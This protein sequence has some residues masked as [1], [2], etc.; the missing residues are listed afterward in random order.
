MLKTIAGSK[1]PNVLRLENVSKKYGTRTVLDGV[2]LTIPA[3]EYVSLL[4][5][6][7]SGKTVLLRVIAGFE[8]PDGGRVFVD[9]IR[10]D[11][12]PAHRRGIG[13]VFQNF[14]LFPHLNVTDNIAYGLTYGTH[15][16]S[17]MQSSVRAMIALVGLEGL[18]DRGVHQIS[19]GQR[20]RVALARTLV[21]EPRLVLL[22]EPLGAL[23]AHLRARMQGE[24]RA[25][26]EQLGV[27][28]LHVTGNET[29]ALAMGDRTI[30][31][32]EGRV[33]QV[34]TP[35]RIYNAP[36]SPDVARF[37]NSYNL[38]EGTLSGTRFTA[39]CGT[40]DV[41]K[42]AA[43]WARPTYAIR[44][45]LVAIRP[46]A[47]APAA[48]EAGTVARFVADEYSGPTILYLFE[49]PD[50]NMVEV[51]DHLSHRAPRTLVPGEDYA[52]VWKSDDAV[53]FG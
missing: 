2:S 8:Q 49:L 40:F 18:E 43:P 25:I 28:F 16:G 36:A 17:A 1:R 46:A 37:L 21:T 14:A 23:D 50:R 4:G 11:G 5:P 3:D 7:G 10:I 39:S 19:G 52:L 6:S 26:R 42:P 20:Q 9:D 53:V 32:D 45:D 44:Q 48:G 15:K 13:F 12:I 35:D 47:E 24:L 29:E 27:T 30:V 31:L 41:V 38:F 33:A 34:D 51:E 22:D